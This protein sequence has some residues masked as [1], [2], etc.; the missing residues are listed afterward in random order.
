MAFIASP[1]M[2]GN[3]RKETHDV[4]HAS[5]APDRIRG[6]RR[7]GLGGHLPL[8]GQSQGKGCLFQGHPLAATAVPPV[9]RRG[10]AGG[11][12]G[13]GWR[14]EGDQAAGEG[15]SALAGTP[16]MKLIRVGDGGDLCRPFV[17]VFVLRDGS[18][19]THALF[20]ASTLKDAIRKWRAWR[21]AE[22]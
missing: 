19:R 16:A 15:A 4:V 3:K 11:Q 12:L 1:Q 2:N 17:E 20:T 18:W 7:P 21:K 22:V 8:R 5:A 10:G 14:L 13:A 6:R 9:C